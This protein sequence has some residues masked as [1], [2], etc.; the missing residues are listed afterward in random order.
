[1]KRAL[2][3]VFILFFS[4]T[5]TAEEFNTVSIQF[6]NEQQPTVEAGVGPGMDVVRDG[7]NLFMLQERNLVILSIKD[8]G[9]PTVVGE[10]KGIGNLRQI[11]VRGDIA[12]INAR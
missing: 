1:M 2:L 8:P 4:A 7:D 11:V 6:E 12:Y 5:V 10:L 9:R 3:L